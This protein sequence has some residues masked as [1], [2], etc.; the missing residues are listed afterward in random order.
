MGIFFEASLRTHTFVRDRRPGLSNSFRAKVK[1]HMVS[2]NTVVCL[3][4]I[5][6]QWYAVLLYVLCAHFT[7]FWHWMHSARHMLNSAVVF[8][9]K[10]QTM[11][12]N[13]ADAFYS[14]C[15][16][17]NRIF[18]S[19]ESKIWKQNG[20]IWANNKKTL[21]NWTA[22]SLKLNLTTWNHE[23]LVCAECC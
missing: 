16:H 17:E 23:N 13:M 8:F 1:L 19:I 12:G 7:Q 21:R 4:M 18:F 14:Q 2:S 15:A 22:N 11:N 3:L 5:S 10:S 9:K 20:L 6:A